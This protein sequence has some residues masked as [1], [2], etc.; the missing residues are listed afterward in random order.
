VSERVLLANLGH[1][2]RY[3]LFQSHWAD[4]DG[5]LRA[6]ARGRSDPRTNDD[7]TECG[8]RDWQSL[9]D[10]LSY[11]TLDLCLKQTGPETAA[12]LPVW[13]G[14][15]AGA[16]DQTPAECGVLVRIDSP[17]EYDRLR[18]RLR[19]QK[20]ELG[21]AIERGDID[22]ETAQRRLLADSQLRIKFVSA[23]AHHLV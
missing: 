5:L 1:N 19:Q 8:Q 13:A 16:R 6:I 17:A 11:L 3:E 12:Y 4:V 20:A 7:W 15:P 10:D 18:R 9:V 23:S 22:T 2:G 14:I 21:V